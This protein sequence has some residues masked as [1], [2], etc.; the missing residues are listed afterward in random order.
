MTPIIALPPQISPKH[1]TAYMN[2]EYCCAILSAG[3]LPIILPLTTDPDTLRRYAE[4]CHGLLLTGGHDIAPAIYGEETR[5][6]CG[7]VVPERDEME[8]KLLDMFMASD[9]PILGICRGIQLINAHLGGTLYQHIPAQYETE[10]VHNQPAPFHIPS[11]SVSLSEPLGSLL[12]CTSLAVNSLHHQA[13]KPPAPGLQVTALSPDGLIEALCDP[14]RKFFHAV[15]W[16]PE[17]MTDSA[18]KAVFA[19]FVAA[20]RDPNLL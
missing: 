2:H 1:G 17:K 15:Q 9:K 3:G 7:E 16:H 4:M 10:L 14:K 12:G 8:I 6:D 11:H 19:A 20:C 18:S 5:P 13:V